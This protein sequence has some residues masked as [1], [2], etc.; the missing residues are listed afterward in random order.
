MDA[1]YMVELKRNWKYSSEGEI[2]INVGPNVTFP[3][4]ASD[5]RLVSLLLVHFHVLIVKTYVLKYLR[6]NQNVHSI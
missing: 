2:L 5:L 1:P 3:D 6:K 4:F